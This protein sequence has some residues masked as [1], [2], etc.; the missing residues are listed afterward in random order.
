M[1]HGIDECLRIINIA[2]VNVCFQHTLPSSVNWLTQSLAI[3]PENIRKS[4]T[5]LAQTISLLFE[6]FSFKG[7]STYSLRYVI[8]KKVIFRKI[9]FC[10]YL[11]CHKNKCLALNGHEL[12]YA[13]TC[14]TSLM[15]Q[16]RLLLRIWHL[17]FCWPAS[18][19]N[20]NPLRVFVIT[21]ETNRKPVSAS[22]Q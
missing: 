13:R 20:L 1:S 14:F 19:V 2:K 15:I 6:W 22:I 4:S 3:R 11:T 17:K 12:A 7:S 8:A 16:P 18:N 10:Q 21:E 9:F 5:R